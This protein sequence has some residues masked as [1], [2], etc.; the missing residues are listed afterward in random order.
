[1]K[2][3]I[4][5]IVEPLIPRAVSIVSE[6]GRMKFS[7][8]NLFYK[9]REIFLTENFVC[10]VCSSQVRLLEFPDT[11]IC[12][13]EHISSGDELKPTIEGLK[14][15]VYDS[16]S[17]DFLTGYQRKFGRIKGLL[18]EE[19]GKI[20]YPVFDK[21]YG[22]YETI[23]QGID[24]QAIDRFEPGVG[25]KVIMVEKIGLLKM[26]LANNFD[27]RLD[28]ILLSTEGFTTEAAR[29]IMVGAA[30]KGFPIC[31]LHD[32]DINGLL[33]YETLLEPTKRRDSFI[34][35]EVYDLGFTYEQLKVLKKRPEPVELMKSDMG[36]LKGL[37]SRGK[38]T[39]EEYKFLLRYRVEL[40]TLTPL[41]LLR[42]L[43]EELKKRGLWKRIPPQDEFR[44][45][46]EEKIQSELLDYKEKLAGDVAD[47]VLEMFF[48]D[49][50]EEIITEIRNYAESKAMEYI[51]LPY[52]K[53]EANLDEL[54]ERL[55]KK[56]ESYWKEIAQEIGREEAWNYKDE[57]E[58]EVDEHK[59]QW[60]EEIAKDKFVQERVEE[61]R[62]LLE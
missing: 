37:L 31:I 58:S 38:I 36:K 17:Q 32:Y 29:L 57:M 55:K 6:G 11:F 54:I 7:V 53:S 35:G 51:R 13:G 5:D 39:E 9:V 48:L 4:K 16:F 8:R 14:F 25:N 18:N 1:M 45:E 41:E 2:V 22:R 61:I 10:P 19:R 40:N 30:A 49:R 26:M 59:E 33:I 56:P 24:T 42:W 12:P 62:E 20:A 34:K 27:Q 50:I 3:I 52:F 15:Y 23:E 46:V 21:R 28:A 43:E 44:Y 60:A 47:S